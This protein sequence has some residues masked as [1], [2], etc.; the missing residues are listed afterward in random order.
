MAGLLQYQPTPV[1]E[2][3]VEVVIEDLCGLLATVT[4]D[5]TVRRRVPEQPRSNVTFPTFVQDIFEPYLLKEV[6]K[7]FQKA[8]GQLVVA[9]FVEERHLMFQEE[10][11]N[12][13]NSWMRE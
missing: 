8:Q 6:G 11:V 13:A 3:L 4:R 2:K 9:N 10:M 5:N 12:S 1:V 7:H